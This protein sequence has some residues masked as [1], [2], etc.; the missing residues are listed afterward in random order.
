MARFWSIV[1]LHEPFAGVLLQPAQP[2]NCQPA[3]GVWVSVTTSSS[4]VQTG[5]GYLLTHAS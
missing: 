4:N 2:V 3:A 5:S 1:R